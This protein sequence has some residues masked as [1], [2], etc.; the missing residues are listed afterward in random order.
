M[1]LDRK[2]KLLWFGFIA[3]AI[4]LWRFAVAALGHEPTVNG[5]SL[6]QLI[7]DF[8]EL[9]GF[10]QFFPDQKK[11]NLL[12][13][14]E[15]KEIGTNAIP[16]LLKWLEWKDSPAKQKLINL[17][18]KLPL[19]RG[20]IFTEAERHEMAVKCFRILGHEASLPCLC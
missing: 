11:R 1:R 14:E 5:Q 18:N 10:D 12:A 7:Q 16:T 13:T 9:E 20:H 6:S 17:V 19:R 15:I 4:V 3:V 2:S 8:H